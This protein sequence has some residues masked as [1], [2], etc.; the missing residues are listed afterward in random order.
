[1]LLRSVQSLAHWRWWRRWHCRRE[2]ACGRCRCSWRCECEQRW[3][4]RGGNAV[5]VAALRCASN[6]RRRWSSA[7]HD[8]GQSSAPDIG[9]KRVEAARGGSRRFAT[10][11]GTYWPFVGTRVRGVGVRRFAQRVNV[12]DCRYIGLVVWRE[13]VESCAVA[14]AHTIAHPFACRVLRNI[15]TSRRVLMLVLVLVLLM[16][17]VLVLL[18][19]VEEVARRCV[20]HL[21]SSCHCTTCS[22]RCWRRGRWHRCR[23]RMHNGLGLTRSIRVASRSVE[24]IAH[25]MHTVAV[26]VVVATAVDSRGCIGVLLR[27]SAAGIVGAVMACRLNS[28]T[29]PAPARVRRHIILVGACRIAASSSVRA[30]GMRVWCRRGLI[31]LWVVRVRCSKSA[32][33]RVRILM[34]MVR[35]HSLWLLLLRLR[36]RLRLRLMLLLLLLLMLRLLILMGTILLIGWHARFWLYVLLRTGSCCC[37]CCLL[38]GRW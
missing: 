36:L 1:L 15:G 12:V 25:L 35:W 20:A 3:R 27:T 17:L 19:V 34:V 13:C 37:C 31:E 38:L 30:F 14:I 16:V 29:T 23:S 11:H 8:I 26:R 10:T 5:G 9:S 33:A 6:R 2:Q 24:S 32:T 18:M 22:C 21:S 7:P 4:Q 28:T